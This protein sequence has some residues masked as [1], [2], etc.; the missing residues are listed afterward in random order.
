MTWTSTRSPVDYAKALDVLRHDPR[1]D[2]N[3]VFLLGHSIG[4]AIAPRLAQSQPVSGIIFSDGVARDWFEYE[5]LNLRRQLE[6]G[7][8]RPDVVDAKM[9]EKARCMQRLLYDKEP[10]ADIERTDPACKV[11]NRVY[12]VED[13]Y[14]QQVAALDNI[15]P[16]EH[17]NIPVLAI[18]GTSDFV[19]DPADH[20]RIVD[21]VNAHT[22][23]SATLAVVEG[24]DHPLDS[25][26]T[27]EI[28]LHDSETG[29][30][31]PY[32]SDFSKIVVAWLLRYA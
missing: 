18:Y 24:M 9:L 7:G 26:A 22:H 13:A 25:A 30:A 23:G 19:V 6:L 3:H 16:W 21:V 28:A 5:L 4:T 27:Q 17:L 32:K 10:E 31:E 12:P 2:P 29:A 14:V 8:D 11:H 20:R 15:G 1:V